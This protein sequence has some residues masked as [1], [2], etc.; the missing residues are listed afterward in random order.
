M[1]SFKVIFFILVA[2]IVLAGLVSC[3][4]SDSNSNSVPVAN[5]GPDQNITTGSLV[6]LDG[7][8]STDADGNPLT[9]SWS[10][11]SMPSG[12]TATLSSTA[13]VNPTFTAD[14]D[15]VYEVSLVV[16]D[17]TDNSEVDTVT[18]TAYRYI[19]A[20]NFRVIDSEY[21]KSLDKIIMVSSTPSN[22]LH[23][24]D[25]ITEQDIALNLNLVPTCVS[26]SPD[27]LYAAAGHNGWISYVNLS[28][29]TL[30]T[31]F[32]VSTDVFDIVLGGN[33]YVYAFPRVDQWERIRCINLTTGIETMHTGNYIYDQTRAK[34]HPGGTA[35]YLYDSPYH[36]DFSMCGDLWMSEDGLRIF[37]KCGNV[38]RSS[39]MQSED[40]TYNGALEN[41]SFVRH[42]SHSSAVGKV[43]AVPD[44]TYSDSTADREVQIFNYDYLTFDSKI[45]LPHFVVSASSAFAGHGRF[46]FYNSTGTKYF[47]VIQ[48]DSSS[49]MLYDYGVVSY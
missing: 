8:G 39:S 45:T 23:I 22:Q 9:Y 18:I 7:S 20:M 48:A 21:S 19:H 26:V 44:N 37:T 16:N 49:G 46:V 34:L 1:K 4:S 27:G 42:L 11:T 2:S 31:I 41:L 29:A 36:G 13:V 12:S 10:F 6:T 28:T 24:Y 3:G 47:V 35:V 17:G 40:M 33:G 15:G 14:K 43:A 5:A 38:F 32:P 25:P 30:I